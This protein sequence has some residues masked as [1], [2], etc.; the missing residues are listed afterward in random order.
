MMNRKQKN[1]HAVSPVVGVMLMLVVTIIIAAVVSGFAGSIV[2]G[3]KKAPT[4]TADAEITNTGLYYGSYFSLVVTGVSEAIPSKDV[5]IVTSWKA[6]DGTKNTT[7]VMPGNKTNWHYGD[8][9]TG[10]GGLY[11]MNGTAPWATGP[12]IPKFDL[13]NT[14]NATQ[15][16]G[17]YSITSGT[18]MRAYPMG[19]WG[20]TPA[21]AGG[22][23]PTTAT[24]QYVDGSAFLPVSG[25]E[26]DAMQAVLGVDWN[27]L[28]EG[29]IVQVK[30]VHVPSG[31]ILFEK[32]VPVRGG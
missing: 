23:G 4:L 24:Y 27:H 9:T 30:M 5:M 18:S 13:Y 15:N 22:Y 1:E 29:D 28:R 20:P 8:T 14:K 32:D 2:S 6:Q 11:P 7:K 16:F 21:D 17:N 31:K 19:P 3:E 25:G 10:V 12:G 26:T